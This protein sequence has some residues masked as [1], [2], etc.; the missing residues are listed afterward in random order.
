MKV[1]LAVMARKIDWTV[2]LDEPVT[3]FPLWKPLQVR[4][5]GVKVGLCSE[6]PVYNA[7][8]TLN[9]MACLE[10]FAMHKLLCYAVPQLS[11]LGEYLLCCAKYCLLHSAL[12]PGLTLP[13]LSALLLLCRECQ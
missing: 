6:L 7:P 9:R 3:S 8:A 2:D 13:G 1:L 4:V 5:L 11:N 10:A 12:P